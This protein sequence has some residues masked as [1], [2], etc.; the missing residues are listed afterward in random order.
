[1]AAEFLSSAKDIRTPGKNNGYSGNPISETITNGFF[2][3]DQKWTVKY[4]NKAAENILGIQAKDIVGLNLW[5]KVADILPVE[6]YNVYHLAFL[7]NSPVHF[8]E[9]W[10]RMGSW[11]DVIT[12]HCD[13]TLSVSF[14]SSNKPSQPE[15]PERQLRSLNE[16]YRFVTEVTND[17]LW[18][19]NLTSK[20]FFWIDGGHKRVFGYP[21]VNALVPQSFWESLLHP[22]DKERILTRLYKIIKEGSTNVW[23]DEYRFKKVTGDYAH[24][25][26]RG[27]IIYDNDGN[28]S[29]MIGATQDISARK[30]AENKLI[31]ERLTRQ[32]EITYAVLTAQE[33]E[34][35]NI[36]RELHDNV[37]Q[38]LGA[39]KLYIE[40]AKKDEEHREIC[41]ERSCEYIV[42]VIEDIRKIA[43]TLAMPKMIKGLFESIQFLVDDLTLVYPIKFDFQ[44]YAVNEEEINENLQVDIYRIVQEQLN[45]ILKHAKATWVTINLTR[46]ANEITLLISDNGQGCDLLKVKMG[47]GI[48]N[49][50][51]RAEL[52]KGKVTTISKPGEG[53]EL[54]VV[55]SLMERINTLSLAM[56][57]SVDPD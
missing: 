28:A 23:E 37:N 45:N 25:H 24:V 8:E 48:I 31:Q 19:W 33:K 16:L 38:I 50:I 35:E 39:A 7:Q 46:A 40:T 9:Y 2:T 15:N 20:E 53:Y 17:C 10:G 14:K 1:M 22:E 55:L 34:R 30:S 5:E 32:K 12:Y 49:I 42:S 29:M 21:I 41:L 11:F 57:D 43:T 27:H 18:E 56:N 3:V 51:S 6:F 44:M 47:M 54:K 36:G 13:D 4:C 52:Y 26:D